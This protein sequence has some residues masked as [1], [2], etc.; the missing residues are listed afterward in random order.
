[1]DYDSSRSYIARLHRFYF[2]AFTHEHVSGRGCE[3]PL[4]HVP[5]VTHLKKFAFGAGPVD[6]SAAA[7]EVAAS[8]GAQSAAPRHGTC[9]PA[10]SGVAG[11]AGRMVDLHNIIGSW[12]NKKSHFIF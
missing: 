10:P 8:P 1:M 11:P 3:R 9:P 2:Y 7:P 6:R 4:E 5:G 12:L